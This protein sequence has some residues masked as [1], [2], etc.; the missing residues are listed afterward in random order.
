[1]GYVTHVTRYS[2]TMFVLR[3]QRCRWLALFSRCRSGCSDGCSCERD[4]VF[5]VGKYCYI[6]VLL[7]A[8]IGSA[9][10]AEEMCGAYRCN[11]P[12]PDCLMGSSLRFAFAIWRF[13]ALYSYIK[14]YN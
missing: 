11:G 5:V 2:Y 10:T 13:Y 14:D 6:A 9:P 1:M 3:G 7:T 12:R 4:N 8:Q